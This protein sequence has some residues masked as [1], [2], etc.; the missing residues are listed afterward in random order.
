MSCRVCSSGEELDLLRGCEGWKERST[1]GLAALQ[2]TARL[3]GI[4]SACSSSAWNDFSSWL[5]VEDD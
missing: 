1:E 4:P 3:M 5:E 2:E